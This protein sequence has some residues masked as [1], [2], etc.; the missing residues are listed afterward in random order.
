MHSLFEIC[1]KAIRQRSFLTAY[2][3]TFN[4]VRADSDE[5]KDKAFRLRYQVHR[6]ENGS[7]SHGLRYD[8]AIERDMYDS[9]AVH[10]LLIH[11]P[12]GEVMGTVRTVL[13][14]D[15]NPA[16]SFPLQNVCDHP[17]IH[18]EEKVPKLCEISSLCVAAKFRRRPDDG[19]FLPA[20]HDQDWRV[21]FRDGHLA[22]LRRRIPYAPLGLL[23]AAFDAALQAKIM[24]C[25]LAVEPEH[26]K[27]LERIGF[28]YRPLGPK[29]E[30]H[31]TMQQPVVFNIKHTLDHMLTESPHCWDVVSD[32][33]ALHKTANG[34]YVNEWQDRLFDEAPAADI[35][36]RIF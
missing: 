34:L 28:A 8:D 30:L 3:S 14:S 17:Y 10:H 36:D 21:Q 23:A 11:K 15:E 2:R 20:Y 24:D 12:S 5:Q 16:R 4:V 6:L 1:L 26:L 19:R 9:H 22:Y 13:P 7:T 25:V 29:V 32:M 33:G 18:T 31:G 27:S 35:Y